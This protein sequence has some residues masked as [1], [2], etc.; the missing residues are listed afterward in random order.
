MLTE[1]EIDLVLGKDSVVITKQRVC[2][3]S[4]FDDLFDSYLRILLL[5]LKSTIRA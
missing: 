2:R 4:Y 1:R 3:I 5:D